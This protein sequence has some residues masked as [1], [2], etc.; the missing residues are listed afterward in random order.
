M[1]SNSLTDTSSL[2][3]HSQVRLHSSALTLTAYTVGV[4][5]GR[6]LQKLEEP[7]V[8][9]RLT[10]YQ[11]SFKGVKVIMGRN[12]HDHMSGVYKKFLAFEVRPDAVLS[13]ATYPIAA[14][15]D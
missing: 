11:K 12:R 14:F 9:E 7:D 3:A 1:A 6:V 10:E 5:P 8:Q 4:E 15:P 13:H 2:S